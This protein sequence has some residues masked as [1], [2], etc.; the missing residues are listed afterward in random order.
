MCYHLIYL[1]IYLYFIILLFSFFVWHH[2]G[3]NPLV[4]LG[5]YIP[6][7][8]PAGCTHGCIPRVALASAPS[9]LQPCG[10]H[11]RTARFSVFLQPCQFFV[12]Q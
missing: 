2:V 8:H 10:W 3:C 12:R 9:Q 5:G 6:R 7:E 1:F 4:H 11:P